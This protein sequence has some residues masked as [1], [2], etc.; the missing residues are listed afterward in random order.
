MI[1]EAAVTAASAEDSLINFD[2]SWDCV[3]DLAEYSKNFPDCVDMRPP[4]AIENCAPVPKF[5]A[6]ELISEPHDRRPEAW[7]CPH[8]RPY[9]T[10]PSTIRLENI[11]MSRYIASNI[12]AT[13]QKVLQRFP[14]VADSTLTGDI[15]LTS[16]HI[17][18][19][20]S[21]LPSYVLIL[22]K[23]S[24]I[25]ANHIDQLFHK[26]REALEGFKAIHPEDDTL[27]LT[28]VL[29]QEIATLCQQVEELSIFIRGFKEADAKVGQG[30]MRIFASSFHTKLESSSQT[31]LYSRP[32]ISELLAVFKGIF[33]Q[34]ATLT[35]PSEFALVRDQLRLL[36]FLQSGF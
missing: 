22:I 24:V 18:R 20:I 35:H 19:H 6:D 31:D 15:V 17:S 4:R 9:R 33:E 5:V 8:G 7:C 34:F 2:P 23:L 21:T 16:R 11:I 3:R 13:V 25:L 27:S 30:V 12:Y 32:V 36:P 10:I 26:S 29:S 1:V 28:D 14:L